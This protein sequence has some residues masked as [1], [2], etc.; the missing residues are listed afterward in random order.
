M[1]GA[2]RGEGERWAERRNRR[3]PTK[4]GNL[5]EV[6]SFGGGATNPRKEPRFGCWED[7][8]GE[9]RRL[10]R[11]GRAVDDGTGDKLGGNSMSRAEKLLE[12]A[13]EETEG[14]G[15][16]KENERR[17]AALWGPLLGTTTILARV[18]KGLGVET[19]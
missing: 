15:D 1:M 11:I 17:R 4:Y 8:R 2:E 5:G 19:P 16:G 6:E 3:T 7:G 10:S 9:R 13:Q 18:A 14:E 12:R